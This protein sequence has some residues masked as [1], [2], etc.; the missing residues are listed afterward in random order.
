MCGGAR[1]RPELAWDSGRE[2]TSPTVRASLKT[3]QPLRVPQTPLASCAPDGLRE[4]L[5]FR[6]KR[7]PEGSDQLPGREQR[8]CDRLPLPCV[9]SYCVAALRPLVRRANQ[10][11]YNMKGLPL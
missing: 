2:S 5:L 1:Q 3:A 6:S 7:S 4:G 11:Q 9:L 8:S 10:N